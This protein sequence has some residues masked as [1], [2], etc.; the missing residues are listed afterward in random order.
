MRIERIADPADPRLDDYRELAATE[1][2]R[3]RGLFIA[4]GRAVVRRLVAGGRHRVW[5]ILATEAAAATL[6]D[7]VR[8][9]TPVW[10]VTPD[11]IRAVVGYAFHR[12]CLALGERA[13]HAPVEPLLA[14]RLLV[15][16]ERVT[17]PDNVG[18]VFRS[19]AALGADGVVLSPGCADPLYRKAIR[20]SMG[21]AVT[22]PFATL[23]EWPDGL[24]PL[25]AAGFTVVALTPDGEVAL[26][27]L[28]VPA[29]IALVLGAEGE[30]LSAAARAAADV[31]VRI[32]MRPGDHSLNVAT[33]C[34]IAL[35]RLVTLEGDA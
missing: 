23:G 14:G 18:G 5:S 31:R 27:A 25:R 9:G 16:L 24:A 34:A 33:A 10:V 7:V 21:A 22:M 26:D 17:N 2:H 35:H 11:A 1:T 8:N 3:R 13:P 12:G 20:V 32:P 29:R 6:G 28:R 15:V 4:E 19:A 30:G